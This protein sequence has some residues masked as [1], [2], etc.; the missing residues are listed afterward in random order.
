MY[1]FDS[2]WRMINAFSVHLI[3][4]DEFNNIRKERLWNKAKYIDCD[5]DKDEWLEYIG[6]MYRNTDLAS[7][8]WD[9]KKKID[10]SIYYWEKNIDWSK[11]QRINSWWWV[12]IK[13]CDKCNIDIQVHNLSWYVNIIYTELNKTLN[14]L[15]Y[16]YKEIVNIINSDKYIFIEYN[17]LDSSFIHSLRAHYNMFIANIVSIYEYL[18]LFIVVE[19]IFYNKNLKN[20]MVQLQVDRAQRLKPYFERNGLLNLFN[21]YKEY[22]TNRDFLLHKWNIDFRFL[23]DNSNNIIIKIKNKL[24]IDKVNIDYNNIKLIIEDFFNIYVENINN[25]KNNSK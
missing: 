5:T 2:T 4:N 21:L 19:K 11:T 6:S 1:D 25:A 15:D 18:D 16:L 12:F 3:N 24:L 14:E 10:N 13:F 23:K 22:K 8:F 7:S 20:N 9:F 17:N